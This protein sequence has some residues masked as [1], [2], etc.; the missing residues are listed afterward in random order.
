MTT[1]LYGNTTN[2]G[3]TYF[4]WFVFQEAET[5]PATPTGGS[6]NFQTNVGIAPSGWSSTPPVNPTTTVWASITI[7][8][9]RSSLALVW[10]APASW[11]KSGTPGA[12]ATIAVG[13]TTTLSPGSSATVANSGTSNAAVFNFGIPQGAV[14][15]TGP[16]GAT[17]AT[18]SPG[19]AATVAAGTTTTGSP[20]TSAIVANSGT[21][22]AAVFDFTIPRGEVGA[23]GPAGATGATG[24]AAT[25]AAGSTTTL[26][27]GTPAAV[28]NVGT[29]SAAVFNFAIP[30]GS[31][32]ATGA[33]GVPG[34]NWLGTWSSGTTYA[35]RD[36][37][38]YN[39]SS[40]YATAASTNQ[41][42]PNASFWNVLAEKGANGTG[43]GSVTSVDV[44]GGTTGLTTS[45]GPITA[46]GTITLAGTLAVANGGTGATTAGGALTNLGALGDITSTDGSVT[47]TSP[48]TTTRDL[49]VAVAA[50]T[51]NVLA[52][53]RN[54]TGA[55]LTKG[56]AVYISGASGQLPTVSKALATSDA[57]SAQTLG[58]ITADLANNSNGNVTVIGLITNIDTSTYTD[59]AQLY[60]SPTTAG[61]LTATKPY[62]PNHLVYVAVVEHAHPTQ[63]KLFV[64]VQN[65]YE[66]DELHDV[67]AQSPTNGQTIVYNSSTNLWEKNTVS[68]TI[69]VNGTL[70]VANGG[71]GA[72]SLT[73]NN[74]ILGNG[75]SAVQVVAPGTAGNVLTSVGG[76][77]VSST[78]SGGGATISNDTATATTVYPLFAAATSGLPTTIYTSNAKYLYQPST[79]TLSASQVNASNGIFTNPT[80]LQNSY[81]IPTG[82]NAMTTG[83]F[84][85][86]GGMAVTVSGGSRWVVL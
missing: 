69:G 62:A 46:A 56:T 8:N 28:T 33:Q 86:P 32:G 38:A 50:A 83:P 14:G 25:V 12:S 63:G 74:V 67:A 54:T 68:L 85:V 47:I 66:L 51:N 45:G 39:G 57:T 3:G 17:G 82:S 81:T 59:G 9:S 34:I 16:A 75:T 48:T 65:G 77:W 1:G 6:W 29:S 49:S 23:T 24:S 4:E 2:F 76:T 15:A 21:S 35:I 18:G 84:T 22:S 78:P 61:A 52:Q 55:T 79:G 30:Q 5:A 44:S 11:V 31:T 53:V 19:A 42:P 10:T 80:T 58:L 73:A 27:P 72:T 43:S 13:T 71:T 60:L 37:V 40:Y 26:S 41:A 64:K 7:V 70:P 20:G 36:A